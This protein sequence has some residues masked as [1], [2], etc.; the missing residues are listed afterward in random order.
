LPPIVLDDEVGVPARDGPIVGLPELW[1]DVID[2]AGV[3][4]VVD[5]ELV[6][7]FVIEK[8]TE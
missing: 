7:L 1:L 3:A 5:P 2:A 8:G 6:M 4:E